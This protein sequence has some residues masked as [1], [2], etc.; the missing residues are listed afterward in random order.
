MADRRFS[1]DHID[2]RTSGEIV[3]SGNAFEVCRYL[4]AWR[5]ALAPEPQVLL[6][7]WR[8]EV[9][10]RLASLGPAKQIGEP[11]RELADGDVL[12][13]KAMNPY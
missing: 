7:P 8:R 13:G 12:S 11:L 3:P 1:A 9:H 6:R 4:C 10:H 2:D 5:E